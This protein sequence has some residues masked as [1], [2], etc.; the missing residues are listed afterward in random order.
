MKTL[1]NMSKNDICKRRQKA[2]Y[3]T[4]AEIEFYN[5]FSEEA[6]NNCVMNFIIY[7]VKKGCIIIESSKD[8]S[9]NVD[10]IIKCKF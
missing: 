1:L 3:L 2:K 10:C 8:I 7:M 9:Y 6:H 5:N 4:K